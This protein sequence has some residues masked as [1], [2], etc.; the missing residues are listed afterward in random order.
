MNEWD[1]V[2]SRL[3]EVREQLLAFNRYTM[4]NEP[5]QP[6]LLARDVEK[7]LVTLASIRSKIEEAMYVDLDPQAKVPADIRERIIRVLEALDL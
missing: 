4:M 6:R 1:E 2:N 3:G 5:T 7:A